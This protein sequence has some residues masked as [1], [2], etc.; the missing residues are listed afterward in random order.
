[1]NYRNLLLPAGW[2]ISKPYR[3]TWVQAGKPTTKPMVRDLTNPHDDAVR[4]LPAVLTVEALA[5]VQ[6]VLGNYDAPAAV[7]AAT[8]PTIV[9]DDHGTGWN[10]GNRNAFFDKHGCRCWILTNRDADGNQDGDADFCGQR[11]DAMRWLRTGSLYDPA[12]KSA[13]KGTKE[14]D[15][16]NATR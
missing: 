1:M 9:K 2:A 12:G 4:V 5:T 10:F 7:L 13:E 8:A 14:I 11:R 6:T 16:P 3:A 15:G